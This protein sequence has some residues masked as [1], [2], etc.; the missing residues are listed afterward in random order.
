MDNT[1]GEV[2]SIENNVTLLKSKLQNQLGDTLLA[3]LKVIKD[4][5]APDKNVD[6]K[7]FVDK[8]TTELKTEL[9]LGE[10]EG[11]LA[12]I[13]KV[14]GNSKG[15]NILEQFDKIQKMV[16]F[17]NDSKLDGIA[18][19][20]NTVNQELDNLSSRR[21]NYNLN[22]PNLKKLERLYDMYLK[23]QN[24][25]E[26]LPTIIERLECLRLIH[27]ESAYL[28]DKIHGL[29]EMQTTILTNLGDNHKLLQKVDENFSKN[30]ATIDNNMKNLEERINKLEK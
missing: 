16:E 15:N 1:T 6:F 3:K 11:R 14:I 26:E 4:G 27:E 18:K 12:N 17:V 8:K 5:G 21:Q 9:K 25:H 13:E 23:V 29:K 30:L 7:L 28:V 20:V 19:K 10:I 2:F 22:D 24:V